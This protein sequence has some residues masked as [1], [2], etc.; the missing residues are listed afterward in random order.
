MMQGIGTD[1]FTEKLHDGRRGPICTC[2]MCGIRE[3]NINFV[4]KELLI[5]GLHY[6]SLDIIFK[7]V[8][9]LFRDAEVRQLVR[10]GPKGQKKL[11]KLENYI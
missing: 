2:A 5:Q 3:H 9:L 11:G 6:G 8:G 10:V 4:V 1:V 7:L